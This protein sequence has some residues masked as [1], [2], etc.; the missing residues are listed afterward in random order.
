MVWRNGNAHIVSALPP[1]RKKRE[2][3]NHRETQAVP[4][5]NR[6]FYHDL[7]SSP[8]QAFSAAPPTFSTDRFSLDTCVSP[9][10]AVSSHASSMRF[11]RFVVST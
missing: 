6:E 11:A 9:I 8:E 2:R 7:W 1:T 4:R 10:V 3:S 5:K